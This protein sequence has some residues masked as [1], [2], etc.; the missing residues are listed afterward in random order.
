MK[1][2]KLSLTLSGLLIASAILVV[3]CKKKDATTTA[4]TADTSTTSTT[5]NQTAQQNSHDITNIGSQ[6]IENDNGSLSTFRSAQGGLASP[7]SASITINLSAKNMTVTFNGSVGLDGHIRNGTL[8]YDWSQSTNNAVWFRDSGLVLNV[9]T[10]GNTYSVDGYTVEII[11]KTITNNGRNSSGYLNWTDNSNIKVI[12]P[13]LAGGGTISWNA[14]WNIA[15][16]NTSTYVYTGYTGTASTYTYSGVFHGYGGTVSNAIDWSQAII[17]VS[18][19]NFGGTASDGETYTGNISSPLILNLNCTTPL[20]S[21]YLY[22][23][24]TL[25]FTP[26][27]KLTRTINYGAGVCDLTYVVSIGSFS[28]TITI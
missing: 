8:Y 26:A 20:Y 13:A 16:L 28:V 9:S 24:G 18:S 11:S 15:L 6:G 14:T 4:P 23:A 3:S 27:G 25:N 7:L 22:V 19:S 12:K 17:S 5:D 21:K 1:K 10:P 2:T